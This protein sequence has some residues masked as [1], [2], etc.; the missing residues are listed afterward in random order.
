MAS[1]V[2][3][4]TARPHKRETHALYFTLRNGRRIRCDRLPQTVTWGEVATITAI[5][6]QGRKPITRKT[7]PGLRTLSFTQVV[8]NRYSSREWDCEEDLSKVLYIS[9]SGA[10]FRIS[11]A[12]S[13]LEQTTW[14][15]AVG[16]SVL[17]THRTSQNRA[18]RAEIE[19]ELQEY[20]E[21]NAKAMKPSPPKRK[22]PVK[23]TPGKS[24]TSTT[25]R[26]YVVRS[27]DSLW[28]ISARLLG[29]GDRWREIYN[30]NRSTVRNPNVLRVGQKLKVPKK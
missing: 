1:R 16:C 26:T 13:P 18:S 22:T 20:V 8:G 23:T 29:R 24:K 11:G 10:P 2:V 5:D 19:W 30:L 9:R 3:V 12:A 14:W 15:Q 4:Y 27:G 17:I 28:K 7:S 25:A 21:D 6:R